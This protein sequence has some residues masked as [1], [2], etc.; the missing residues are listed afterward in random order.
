ML[1]GHSER[2]LRSQEGGS[3]YRKLLYSCNYDR[4]YE[5]SHSLLPGRVEGPICFGYAMIIAIII[6][7]LI[8]FLNSSQVAIA[9]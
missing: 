6:I 1:S 8:C 7:I 3:R 9:A 5:A 4:K 2:G